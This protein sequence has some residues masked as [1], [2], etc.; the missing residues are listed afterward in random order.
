MVRR[1]FDVLSKY[2]VAETQVEK[3]LQHFLS[4]RGRPVASIFS[5][6]EGMTCCNVRELASNAGIEMQLI[7]FILNKL[8]CKIVVTSHR[9]HFDNFSVSV[10]FKGPLSIKLTQEQ[11]EHG[12]AIDIS[13]PEV[14]DR[15]EL[16]YIPADRKSTYS[17]LEVGIMF[18]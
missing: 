10:G 9:I 6:A 15:R 14:T 5:S 8:C 17:I 12:Y 7:E 3:A 13:L 11:V 1:A 18:M 4:K 16:E 2:E